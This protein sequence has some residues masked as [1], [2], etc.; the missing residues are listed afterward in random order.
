MQFRHDKHH[1][2]YVN[3]LNK[4]LDKY[5]KLKN[6]SVEALLQNL[7]Q[8]PVYIRTTVINNGGGHINHSMFWKKITPNGGSEPRGEIGTAIK[9]NFG[10]FGDLQK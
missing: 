6:K 9:D 5:S 2:A 10:S 8:V 1:A 7:Y 3:N 4:V